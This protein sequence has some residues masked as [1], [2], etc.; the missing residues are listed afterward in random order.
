MRGDPKTQE[1]VF[2]QWNLNGT[3]PLATNGIEAGVKVRPTPEELDMMDSWPCKDFRSGWDS[4]FKDKPDKPVMHYCKLRSIE[5][6]SKKDELTFYSLSG[7]CGLVRRPRK[8]YTPFIT[9]LLV[10][11]VID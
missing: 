9:F 11:Y 4:Y 10:Q 1:Q 7:Y 3:G 2:Q 8:N 5:K 6:L